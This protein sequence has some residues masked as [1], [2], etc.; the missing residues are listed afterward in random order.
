[1]A[2]IIPPIVQTP[3]LTPPESSIKGEISNLP[4]EVQEFLKAG[5]DLRLQIIKDMSF[6]PNAFK[7]LVEING[8]QVEVSV[9]LSGEVKNGQNF[10]DNIQ[11]KV[12]ATGGNKAE[13]KLPTAN[14]STNEIVKNQPRAET[15]VIVK[16][17]QAFNNADF[18]PM[19]VNY[20]LKTISKRIN[21]PEN[22]RQILKQNFS[23]AQ[24]S[25]KIKDVSLANNMAQQGG[26]ILPKGEVIQSSIERLELILNRFV[27][28][29][30]GRLPNVAETN[31]VVE[32]IKNE[33]LSLKNTHFTGAA[34]SS[35]DS[36]LLALR[37][38]MGNF[39]PDNLMKMENQKQ[40]LLEIVDVKL[41]DIE[42][43]KQNQEIN[44]SQNLSE[45]LISA[46]KIFK[47]LLSGVEG[48]ELQKLMKIFEPLEK[49]NQTKLVAEIIQK[50]PGANENITESVLN[51]TKAALQK[52]VSAWLGKDLVQDLNRQGTGGQE[53][54][55]R[56]HEVVQ[57]S[58]REVQNWKIIDMPILN[59]E[60]LSHIRIA[61]KNIEDSQEQNK[62]RRKGA[63]AT[64]F[65]VDTNFTALGMFQFDGFSYR[66]ERNFDL[67]IRTSKEIDDDLKKNI[68]AI[69]KTTLNA[70]HYVGNIRINVKENFI[71]I[72]EN[73][74]QTENIKQ[75][76]YV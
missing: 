66:K 35:P 18:H 69:F 1:M 2:D 42:L 57:S 10:P 30:K 6:Q 55:N 16:N 14:L 19:K 22:V 40:V 38:V 8:Q 17:N 13:I 50:F 53:V 9:K 23:N 74:S 72:C 11:V 52:N 62:K 51:Y 60:Q 54:L 67:I 56:L 44:A 28:Q 68:F 70:L 61:I 59:G 73:E 49:N 33:L 58:I 76:F 45:K 71:K 39:L 31:Q 64:R 65:V 15:A 5:Q 48:Q 12:S 4:A 43:P 21:L 75:G 24:V 3:N 25:I 29:T 34:F 41:P 47:N 37:T 26:N 32:Q 27:A 7:A 36:K 20:I 63:K 46:V